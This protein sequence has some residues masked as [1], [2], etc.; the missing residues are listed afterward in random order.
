MKILAIEGV[1]SVYAGKLREH[2]IATTAALLRQAGAPAGRRRLAES[3]G[4]PEA[5]VLE[6]VNRADLVRVKG[7]GEEFS[8]LLEAAGVDT[9][10]ELRRRKAENLHQSLLATNQEKR[11]VR[12][13]PSL[14]EVSRWIEHAKTLEPAVSY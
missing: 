7:I 2:G 13:P 6:W 12:R 4:V 14:S 5:A 1:G 3:I 10:K 9:V 8:D 11:L